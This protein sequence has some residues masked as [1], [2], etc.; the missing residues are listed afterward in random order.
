MTALLLIAP[1][2][3]ATLRVGIDHNEG[4][5]ALL[6]AQWMSGKP[7][8]PAFDALSANNYRLSFLR[9]RWLGRW[10]G[11]LLFAG[12]LLAFIGSSPRLL[13]LQAVVKRLTSHTH[14]AL[15][16]G[17]LLVGYSA[18]LYPRYVGMDDP[19]W[20]GHAV[21]LL[22]LLAFLASEQRGWLFLLS[23]SL[24]LAAGFVKHTGANSSG[25]DALADAV[26]ARVLALWLATCL[27][28]GAHMTLCFVSTV[29][30]S[31]K[32]LPQCS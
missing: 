18:A 14:A 25:Y 3:R 2:W 30:T 6:A 12:R 22:G 26:S 17:L 19:Q 27:A 11:E 16:S 20:L 24:M 23:A 32:G 15:M 29:Q 4:W 31:S 28:L 13:Q 10:L 8:Y 21:M 5:N 1:I 9:D 7:L